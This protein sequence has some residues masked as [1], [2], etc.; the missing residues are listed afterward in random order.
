MRNYIHVNLCVSL[1]VAQLIFVLGIDKTSNKVMATAT[2]YHMHS[3]M[4]VT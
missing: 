2:M 1:F 4:T 3:H